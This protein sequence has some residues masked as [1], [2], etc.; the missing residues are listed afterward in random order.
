[1]A[2]DKQPSRF[3]RY[4]AR[5]RAADEERRRELAS[6]RK[7]VKRLK[8]FEEYVNKNHPELEEVKRLKDLE[9]YVKK[10]NPELVVAYEMERRVERDSDTLGMDEVD[11]ILQAF[12]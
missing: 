10:N 11:D 6:L 12:E 5:Q 2:D 9:A 7:E 1:M 3:Q 8:Q 4:R